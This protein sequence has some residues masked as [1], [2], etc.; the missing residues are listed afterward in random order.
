MNEDPQMVSVL[1]DSHSTL[2]FPTHFYAGRLG[3]RDSLPVRVTGRSIRAASLAGFRPGSSKL[4]VKEEI[5]AALAEAQK[6]VLAFGQVDL[7]LGYYYRL[8]IKQEEIEPTRYVEW[9]LAI[10][11]DFLNGLELAPCDVALKGVNLTA[12]SPRGF[13]TRYVSRIVTEGKDMTWKEAVPV[14]RPHVLSE[15]EQNAMHLAFNAGLAQLTEELGLRYF[16]LN[17]ELATSPHPALAAGPIT[18]ADQ[19]KTGAFDH[20]VADTVV[21]R[22]VHYEGLLKAFDLL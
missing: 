15:G 1:G 8:A 16:D 11:R 13:A 7:E 4:N 22:R 6:L 10:Y 14:V 21:A 20:H 9:L 18:L 17:E 2:F 12:L 19:F 5:S 3:Y